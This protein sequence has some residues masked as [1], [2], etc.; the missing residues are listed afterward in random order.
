MTQ[1][2]Q[3][4]ML[5]GNYSVVDDVI[6][7]LEP[8]KEI[9]R[10]RSRFW[11]KLEKEEYVMLLS[12]SKGQNNQIRDYRQL[13]HPPNA[14]IL[15]PYANPRALWRVLKNLL[16]LVMTPNN[17]IQYKLEGKTKYGLIR[18]IYIYQ[19]VKGEFKTVCLVSPIHNV[20]PKELESSSRLFWYVIFLLKCI[21]GQIEKSRVIVPTESVVCVA[22]Y[23]LLPPD[24][25][26]IKDDGIILQPYDYN[27]Q[28][29][30]GWLD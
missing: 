20:Y 2:S 24:V 30:I 8:G 9:D 25:F 13:P 18:Q 5:S 23:R 4:Q 16:L 6:N 19:D 7:P 21:V 14:L 11:I 26:E 29:D 1:F 22:A 15:Q 3:L 17:C 28:L 10:N 27:S 12:F